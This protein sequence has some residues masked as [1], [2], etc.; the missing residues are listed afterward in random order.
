[1]RGDELFSGKARCNQC[2]VEPLWS[3][4]GWNLHTADEIGIDDFQANRAPDRRYRTSPLGG[5]WTHVGQVFPFKQTGFYHDGRFA[6]L[7]DVVNHYDTVFNLGLT[8][9]E[10][11]DLIEYLKSLPSDEGG[12]AARQKPPPRGKG[13]VKKNPPTS[14]GKGASKPKPR[15]P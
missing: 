1:M 12:G 15:R 7:L 14:K 9:G 8:D 10:K 2:H 6:T 4:P 3:E 11:N 13:P 5:L